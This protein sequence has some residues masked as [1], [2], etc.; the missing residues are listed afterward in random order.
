MCLLPSQDE[1]ADVYAGIEKAIKADKTY[2][3]DCGTSTNIMQSISLHYCGELLYS[4]LHNMYYLT[5]NF[6]HCICFDLCV[7]NPVFETFDTM[8]HGWMAAR[9]DFGNKENVEKIKE[10]LDILQKFFEKTL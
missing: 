8:H 10:G 7:Y 3:D 2:G 9:A 5:S 1:D 6:V 4:R